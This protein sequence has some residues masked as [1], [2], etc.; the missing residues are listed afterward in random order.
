MATSTFVELLEQRC[1]ERKDALFLVTDDSSITYEE[2][3]QRSLIFATNLAEHHVTLGD[4]VVILMK[5]HIEFVVAWFAVLRAGAFTAPLNTELLG[6][7]LDY[8]FGT[9]DATA[10]IVD[11]DLL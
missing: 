1:Q 8:M 4:H 10:L 3:D 11:T 7:H 2:F 5:N 9:S 6:E